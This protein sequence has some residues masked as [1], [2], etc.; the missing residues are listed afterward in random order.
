MGNADIPTAAVDPHVVTGSVPRA[1]GFWPWVV[2]ACVL[3]LA[4]WFAWFIVTAHQT[5]EEVP[6]ATDERRP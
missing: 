5:I 3:Q 2:F 6:L 1:R 4:G